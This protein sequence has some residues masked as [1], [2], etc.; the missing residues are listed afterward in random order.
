[1]GDHFCT[2]SVPGLNPIA[3]E[4]LDPLER[5]AR[6]TMEKPC[7]RMLDSIDVI[8]GATGLRVQDG[9]NLLLKKGWTLGMAQMLKVLH[10][11]IRVG[12]CGTVIAD[13]PDPVPFGVRLILI[14]GLGTVVAGITKAVAVPIR[15]TEVGDVLAVVGHVRDVV[16]IIVR[17]A[18]ITQS[19]TFIVILCG[20]DITRAVII[21]TDSNR[22]I[23]RAPISCT[24][25]RTQPTTAMVG[26]RRP[27][28]T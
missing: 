6:H 28:L 20:I 25:P 9:Y 7:P 14:V 17:I 4:N 16:I 13:I 26:Q 15:L 5:I 2:G 23:I 22:R 10:G 19:I 24:S 1:M 27:R 8:R 11:L 21:T 12:D 18:H 3:N